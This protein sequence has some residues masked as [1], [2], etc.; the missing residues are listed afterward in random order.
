SH[1]WKNPC[2]EQDDLAVLQYTSGS[3]GQP[4]GVMLSHANL[5]RNT[6]MIMVAFETNQQSI[7]MS[8]LP[9]Y[10]DMGLVGGVLESVF[11]GRPVALM[12]PMAFLQKPIRWFRA[13]TKYRA[14]T[15]GG[16]N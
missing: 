2:I 12:S 11:I 10:H 14:T 4:K 13:I 9:T 15:S 7:G 1:L 3:T 16:P 5:V 8:W 6:E